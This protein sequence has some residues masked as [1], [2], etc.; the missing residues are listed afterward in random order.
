MNRP[1][2]LRLRQLVHEIRKE[3]VRLQAGQSD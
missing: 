1:G 2:R 3:V